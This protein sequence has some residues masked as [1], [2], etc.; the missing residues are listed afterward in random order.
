MN[1]R[2]RRTLITIGMTALIL[3]IIFTSVSAM[4]VADADVKHPSSADIELASTSED[5]A[6][7]KLG[8]ADIES[9]VVDNEPEPVDNEPELTNTYSSDTVATSEIADTSEDDTYP[10]LEN[11]ISLTDDEIHT[12]AT[13]VYLEA[14]IESY[15][16]QKAVASVVINR[17]TTQGK[18][19]YEVIY[20]QNQFTPA[21]YIQYNCPTESTLSAV[22][23]VVANGP[24]IPEYVTY[25]RERYFFSWAIDYIKYDHTCFSY[26]QDVY[27]MVCN[28]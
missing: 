5:I 4:N 27:D 14:G 12:L 16:C 28:K 2:N 13:L 17:M 20:A 25:F 8:D 1:I 26:T 11:Y 22:K 18:T 10:I 19:L 7:S 15:E 6:A 21:K 9:E 3:A 23:D 24:S